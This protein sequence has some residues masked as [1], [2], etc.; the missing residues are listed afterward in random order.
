MQGDTLHGL[1]REGETLESLKS[2]PFF[3]IDVNGFTETD[4]AQIAQVHI[5]YAC[6]VY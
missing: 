6:P 1:E 2:E 3:W 4:L 5:M